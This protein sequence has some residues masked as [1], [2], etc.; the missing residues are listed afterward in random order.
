MSAPPPA[1]G[2]TSQDLAGIKS[3]LERRCGSAAVAE[4]LLS[5][6]IETS[7]R[8]L[9][10]GDI[11]RPDQ[12]VGYVYRVALNQLRNFRRKDKSARSSADS[13][14]SL[15]DANAV[16]AAAPIDQA[17]WAR[18][19]REVLAEMPTLRDRQLIVGFYLEEEDKETLCSRLGLTE[20][21]FNRVV[22]RAR[23]RFRELL[24]R[25]GFKRGDFLIFPL[26]L[27]G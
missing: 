22:H 13:L 4:D 27:V 24:E 18:L 1:P 11:A 12:L 7:L 20:E 3:L 9:Q 15:P 19:M 17:M 8:K 2:L 16:D 5:E 26:L 14:E 25:R 21:H 10:S 23:E 6:A